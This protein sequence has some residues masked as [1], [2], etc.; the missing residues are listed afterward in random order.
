MKIGIH[1]SCNINFNY[2]MRTKY[3]AEEKTFDYVVCLKQG[4]S[5]KFAIVLP[6]L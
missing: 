5:N 6:K 3:K 2:I 1:A 4:S